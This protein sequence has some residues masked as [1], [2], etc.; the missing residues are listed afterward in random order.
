MANHQL[1][2]RECESIADDVWTVLDVTGLPDGVALHHITIDELIHKNERLDMLVPLADALSPTPLTLATLDLITRH[3]SRLGVW[4]DTSILP[5]QLDEVFNAEVRAKKA[6]T[7]AKQGIAS[8]P[9]TFSPDLV[10]FYVPAFAD[11]RAF[12]HATHLRQNGYTGEI[13]FAG[14]FGIDQLAYLKRTGVDSFVLP[15]E[16]S[17]DTVQAALN[18]LPT[19]YSGK[20]ADELP[21]FR[22]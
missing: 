13:R 15:S 6:K 8:I 1:I 16:V 17:L 10:L 7:N 18:A 2:T 14:E 9:D 21:M 12:S 3:S 5:E 11:G 4:A 20:D 22:S 19:A